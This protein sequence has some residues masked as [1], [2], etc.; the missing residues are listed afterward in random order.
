MI[1]HVLFYSPIWVPHTIAP[2]F[3]KPLWTTF[4]IFLENFH[5]RFQLSPSTCD[6]GESFSV[7][8]IDCCKSIWLVKLRRVIWFDVVKWRRWYIYLMSTP[9]GTYTTPWSRWAPTLRRGVDMSQCTLTMWV[10]P[11]TPQP[12]SPPP[13]LAGRRGSCISDHNNSC[14][15]LYLHSIQWMYNCVLYSLSANTMNEK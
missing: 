9:P 1:L 7:N 15:E 6:K 14:V 10:S 13:P 12:R 5:T 11:P 8:R 4:F 2:G 3:Q